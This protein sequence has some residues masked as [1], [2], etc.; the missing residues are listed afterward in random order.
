M[1]KRKAYHQLTIDD[2]MIIQAYIHDNRNITQTASRLGV[3]KSTV[4]REISKHQ[5]TTTGLSYCSHSRLNKVGLCNGCR[6]RGQC[7]NKRH[8]YNYVE[9]HKEATR[10]NKA[11]R[12]K[13][14]L[15]PASIRLIDEI[16]TEGVRL[17]Q[18]LH[19]IYVSN[20]LLEAICVERAIRRLCYRGDLTV[21]AV[22][23]L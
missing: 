20:P 12:A 21:K 14:K 23:C 7:R 17:G 3:N 19:H 9:A 10:L 22:C 6:L 4:S 2:R 8:Y 1:R 5:V 11:S 18:S 15:S 13:P 16:V